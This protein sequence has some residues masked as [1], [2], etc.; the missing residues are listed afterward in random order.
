MITDTYTRNMC[1][2][3]TLQSEIVM[4]T[5]TQLLHTIVAKLEV[6]D[7]RLCAVEAQGERHSFVQ[8]TKVVKTKPEPVVQ[9]GESKAHHEMKASLK[10]LPKAKQKSFTKAWK[11]LKAASKWPTGTMPKPKYFEL[12]MQAFA[13]VA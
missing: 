7:T 6:L 12:Q 13:S 3:E 1:V 9:S 2:C 5:N 8:P 10:T 11:V 4:D